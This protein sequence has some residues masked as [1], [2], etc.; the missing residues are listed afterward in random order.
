MRPADRARLAQLALEWQA[1]RD[2]MDAALARHDWSAFAELASEA[3]DI[4][5]L[6][7]QIAQREPGDRTKL[8]HLERLLGELP[9]SPVEPPPGWQDR[10]LSQIAH[11]KIDPGGKLARWGFWI[12][13]AAAVLL[14]T[15]VV[16]Y[17]ARNP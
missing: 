1:V 9:A 12:G 16:V 17:K 7:R 10:V 5:G 11:E 4:G 3:L 13:L 2:K 6:A 15:I 8:G 14:L